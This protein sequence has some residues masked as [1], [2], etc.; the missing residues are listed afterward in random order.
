M[1]PGGGAQYAGMGADLYHREP[2]YREAFESALSFVEPS[3]RADLRSLSL[4]DGAEAAAASHRLESPARAVTLLFLVEYAVAKLLSSWGIEPAGMIGHSA[5]EYAVACLAGVL[6]LRDAVAL[7][8]L[9]GRL[10]ETLPEG[11]MLSVQLPA[12]TAG[13]LAPPGLS[14]AAANAPSLCVL[15]GPT[16]LIA[17]AE[18]IFRARDVECT[19]VHI[20]VAAHSSMV[21]SLLPEFERFCR[22]ITFNRPQVPFVSSV[23]GTWI[24]D[25][26]A[27]DPAYWVRHLRQTVRFADGVQTL[28]ES[29][30]VALMEVGP[31][32]AL[33]GLARQQKGPFAIVTPT[34]RHPQEEAS[35]VAFLLG[36]VGRLWLSG[37]RLDPSRLFAGEVRRRAALPTYPFERQRFWIEPDPVGVS[38][39][40]AEALRKRS[41]IAEWFAAPSWARSSPPPRAPAGEPATWLVFADSSTLS[42][43][44]VAAIKNAGHRVITVAASN[45][46]ADLGDGRY[47]IDPIARPHYDQLAKAL[48]QTGRTP[49]G[50]LHLWATAER[51]KRGMFSRRSHWDSLTSYEAGLGRDFY[52]LVFAAQVF[53]GA[54]TALRLV[55]VSSHMQPAPGD[56][57]VHPEKAVVLGP[58]KV[59][60]REFPQV[61]SSSIDVVAAEGGERE[62][63]ERLLRELEGESMDAEIALRGRDRWVRRFDD[64]RLPPAD[65]RPW[66]RDGGVYLLSGGLG[67][68][69]LRVAEH[70]AAHAKVKLALVGR[71]A[72]PDESRFDDWLQN[73]PA[74]DPTS[75]R[76]GKLRALRARGAEVLTIAADVT[77][78]DSMRRALGQVHARLGPVNGVFH[79]A[80]T[81][82]DEIIALRP[83]VAASSVLDSKM[84]GALVL[85]HVL[86]AEP[87]DFFVSFSSVSSILGL[88]GQ[89]DYTAAN[90]FLDALAHARSGHAPGRTLTIDWNAWQD[91]GMLAAHVRQVHERPSGAPCA[92]Q[93]LRPGAHP[94][95]TE[96]L[97]DDDSATL[98]RY[99]LSPRSLV[100]AE[101]ACRPWR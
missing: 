69:A 101:R 8:S 86:K 81:L 3:L 64:I 30:E 74:D 16:A 25:A 65:E 48:E 67:G 71:T 35:D 15:S 22:T 72:L 28:L 57:E 51:P 26:Q 59:I 38:G 78:V 52:S 61:R 37:V 84:K 47:E 27:T 100:V 99:G 39:A 17:Q 10:F 46:F 96:V 36:A 19:R 23:T 54:S 45:R 24:S 92:R 6:S 5:G 66:L 43:A 63:A 83:G 33:S 88:P 32:R 20:R 1:F 21:D 9:R 18:E 34:M 11:G 44:I 76:I 42:M 85:D 31:G 40:G 13:A 97:A 29:G 55:C 70:L 73:H 90:A 49:T 62:L 75:I 68:I 94:A 82:K 58:C 2:V 53:A 79:A 12:E 4:A 14:L 56:G 7:A 87:L 77:D 93:A 50:L 41:D 60:P 80:G 95:L 89:V 98:F 91:V